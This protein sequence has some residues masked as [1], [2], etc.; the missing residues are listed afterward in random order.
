MTK[1]EE[2]IIIWSWPAGHTAAI[3]AW[4]A[5]LEPLMFEGFLA[6]WV[7]AWGQL[8]TTTDVENFPGFPDG[9]MW[10]DLMIR[11]RDQSLNSWT[12]IVTKTVT[13]VDLSASPFKV[14]AQG[15]DEP[16]LAKTILISTWAVAKRL[17][18]DWEETYW[19]NWV[20]ACAV[21]DWALPMFRNKPLIVIWWGDSACEEAH[22]LTKYASK[23]FM[24]VRKDAMKASKVMQQRV[25]DNEK[26]EIMRNTEWKEITGQD[27]YMTWLT[28]INNQTNEETSLE[29][30]GL[31]YA[32]GHK[33]ATAFLEWQVELDEAWYI[34]TFGHMSTATS[35][36]WVFAAWDVQDKKYRQAIT[37]AGTWC[38]AALEAEH[39]LQD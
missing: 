12:T 29:A 23:V 28:V 1:V 36:P 15:E 24:L 4:R 30:W 2:I 5:L 10:P 31:F 17:W 39:F 13:K 3:Y 6:W 25:M 21:C 22:F 27:G 19:Q 38:M 35:V 7:A 33:P 37:S 26:I 8:T 32:I 9:V 11:M 18:L 14:W 34:K 16:R 20:S